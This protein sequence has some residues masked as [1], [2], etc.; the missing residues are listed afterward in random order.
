MKEG[1]PNYSCPADLFDRLIIER[2]KIVQL[3]TSGHPE[4]QSRSENIE[5]IVIALKDEM[6]KVIA[7]T[8]ANLDSLTEYID[9]LIISVSTV[10]YCENEKAKQHLC[11][12]VDTNKITELDRRSRAANEERSRIK[13]NI[14]ALFTDIQSIVEQRTF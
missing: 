10:S 13:N 2:L 6:K 11:D 1:I 14:N 12:T 3:I 4:A 5:Q 8:R 7:T 9:D